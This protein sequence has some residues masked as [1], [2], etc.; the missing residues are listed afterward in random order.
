MHANKV[1]KDVRIARQTKFL[2][3]TR[4]PS[5]EEGG[6]DSE[7]DEKVLRGGALEGSV[8]PGARKTR[9]SASL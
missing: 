4:M 2:S 7:K 6:G 1:E 3:S 9:K 8:I 5:E